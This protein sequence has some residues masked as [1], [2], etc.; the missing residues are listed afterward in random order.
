MQLVDEQNDV[1]VLRDLVHDRLEALLELTAIL[2]AGNHRR[3]IE[4]QHAIV[5]Q[6]IGALAIG[7]ELGESFHDRGLAHAGLTDENRIVL[8]PARQDL[9]YPLDFL[10]AADCRIELVVRR[11]LGQISAEMIEG[12]SL[13]FLL[14]FAGL[15]RCSAWS[16]LRGRRSAALRH[17]GAE[18]TERFRF[19]GVEVHAGV[20]KNLRR[21]SLLFAQQSE[22]QVLGADITVA[23][24]TRFAH[25]E[26]ENFLGT[27]G[28]REIGS[29]RRCG[30]TLL[31]GLLDLLLNLVEVDAEV[32]EDS[33]SYA[34]ALAD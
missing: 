31:H 30:L 15:R 18:E 24:V 21:D 25:G 19:G 17:F 27:G 26:L 33:G 3:H 34:F 2:G 23:K 16:S 10:G 32:L 11:E 4:R 5:A 6:R 13:G 12:G 20:G 9:H 1:L 14:A 7:D 29:G 22:Q 8:L 28:I